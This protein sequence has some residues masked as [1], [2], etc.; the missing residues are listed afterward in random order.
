MSFTYNIRKDKECLFM[1][2]RKVLII[3]ETNSKILLNKN[4]VKR[5]YSMNLRILNLK[6]LQLKKQREICNLK[7][8]NRIK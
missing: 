4:N 1:F 5:N 3:Y 6:K 8:K 7:N 2:I